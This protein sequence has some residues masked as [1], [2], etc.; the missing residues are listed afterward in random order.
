MTAIIGILNKSAVALAADSAVTVGSVQ[1]RKIYNDANK[2]FNLSNNAP[3]GIMIYNSAEFIGVPWETIIKSY[4][5][6]LG[7]KVFDRLT[8]YRDDFMGFIIA[9]SEQIPSLGQENTLQEIVLS[10]IHRIED[11]F[12]NRHIVQKYEHQAWLGLTVEA[13]QN[14]FYEFA[15]NHLEIQLDE[16]Q[17]QGGRGNMQDLDKEVFDSFALPVLQQYV[18][19]W[20]DSHGLVSVEQ[21][22]NAKEAVNLLPNVVFQ[23]IIKGILFE[24]Y[25]GIVISGFGE[26]EFFPSVY[27]INVSGVINGKVRMVEENQDVINLQNTAI[28]A[29]YGQTDIID[30]FVQGIDPFL[31]NT[32][33]A[34]F[35]SLLNKIRSEVY[36]KLSENAGQQKEIDA[37]LEVLLPETLKVLN[38]RLEEVRLKKHTEPIVQTIGTLS[39]E[40]LAEMAE[41]LVNLTYLKRRVSFNEESVGGP[42]DVAIITKGDGFVWI[43]RKHYFKAEQ[44][45]NYIARVL[46][47]NS[48]KK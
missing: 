10:I 33:S 2:L 20:L 17:R 15:R 45:L 14:E 40:D 1:G 44:N 46:I 39:K 24:S 32:I 16:L 29:P 9:Q 18:N 25:T 19:E 3:V 5:R 7:S 6:Q 4:R 34:V 13:Q 27:A 31:S 23:C 43:K 47:D 41:S 8:D 48:I 35:Q 36:Q 11:Y 22:T 28:I 37:F 42:V 12:W 30:A 38:S 21:N 26:A